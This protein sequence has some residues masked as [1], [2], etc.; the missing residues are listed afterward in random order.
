MYPLQTFCI[1]WLYG[2]D[3]F[4]VS[5]VLLNT[6]PGV[7]LNSV[8]CRGAGRG[9]HG[10]II[11][12]HRNLL[13]PADQ[14]MARQLPWPT[15]GG[16]GL[17]TRAEMPTWG[18]P[19]S[20]ATLTNNSVCLPTALEDGRLGPGWPWGQALRMVFWVVDGC[21]LA[22]SPGRESETPLS[23]PFHYITVLLDQGT[24]PLALFNPNYFWKPPSPD[25]VTLGLGGEG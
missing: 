11:S 17:G 1:W 16:W 14:F 15:V 9:S 20:W 23:S 12:S 21:S 10:G 3:F 18:C 2:N 4:P 24:T 13:H 19:I 6:C 22:S 7:V 5:Q 25:M 8:L